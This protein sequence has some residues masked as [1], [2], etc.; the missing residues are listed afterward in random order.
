MK[1]LGY[2]PIL[3]FPTIVK[4]MGP[5][6]HYADYPTRFTNT[7][8]ILSSIARD[9]A[10]INY[11]PLVHQLC[12]T[13]FSHRLISAFIDK[14]YALQVGPPNGSQQTFTR[15]ILCNSLIASMTPFTSGAIA[16]TPISASM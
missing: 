14:L 13:T 12:H 4:M 2:N 1:I 3:D 9:P 5:T 15:T 6:T 10:L 16:D 8:S 11:L 7:M